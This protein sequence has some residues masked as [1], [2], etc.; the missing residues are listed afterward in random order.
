MINKYSSE[1][2][3]LTKPVLGNILVRVYD[4]HRITLTQNRLTFR[5]GITM[6]LIY[7]F[8]FDSVTLLYSKR[9]GSHA[10]FSK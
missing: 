1:Y 4:V 6:L 10:L 7:M 5:Y 8:H 2:V 9:N 3:I